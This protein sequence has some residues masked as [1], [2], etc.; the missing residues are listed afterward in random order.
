MTNKSNVIRQA[1]MNYL[2]PEER[3][4][5]LRDMAAARA[6]KYPESGNRASLMHEGP[7]QGKP[8]HPVQAAKEE[9]IRR[10]IRK[11]KGKA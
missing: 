11:V 6:G 9:V 4:D 8:A 10:A 7:K 3:D 5:V 2:T 1:L